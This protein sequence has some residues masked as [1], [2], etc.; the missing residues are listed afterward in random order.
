MDHPGLIPIVLNEVTVSAI[1]LLR[2]RPGLWVCPEPVWWDVYAG[3]LQT[4][5]T[6]RIG[7]W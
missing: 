5:Y 7:S 2:Y 3:D 6:K 1:L 4:R